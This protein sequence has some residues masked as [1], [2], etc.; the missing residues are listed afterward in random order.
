MLERYRLFLVVAGVSVAL[1][2]ATA[3]VPITSGHKAWCGGI[4]NQT[5]FLA[6][7]NPDWVAGFWVAVVVYAVLVGLILSARALRA[8]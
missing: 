5:C 2:L 7:N 8:K 6:T 3:L 1:G 4:D